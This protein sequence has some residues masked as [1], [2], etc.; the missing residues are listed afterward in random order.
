M[1]KQQINDSLHSDTNAINEIDNSPTRVNVWQMFDRIANRYD[2]LNRL[3]SFGQDIIWRKKVTSH[4]SGRENQTVLDIA[5][6]TG[7]LLI[8]MCLLCS[9]ITHA[10]GIDM[11][12]KMLQIGKDKLK[13]ENL[14]ESGTLIRGDACLLPCSSGMFDAVTIA[15]GI[16]NVINVDGALNE[17]FRVLNKKGRVII[18]EFSLPHNTIIKAFY[19]FYFRNIL[20]L[21]GSL[22]S[23][24]SIAYRY[25]N[26][27]VETFPFGQSFCA[28]LE[29]A[30]FRDVCEQRLMFG[31]ATI[32]RGEKP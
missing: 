16:R 17:M 21:I 30:G 18:L 26:K 22:I 20:P 3:L 9:S 28:L 4:L 19:L 14:Q 13:R 24:N 25:L 15:F 10:V 8:S 1:N 31:V 23:G 27:T 11:A 32:Y 7:D 12:G 6:G 29:K 5:T 2:L